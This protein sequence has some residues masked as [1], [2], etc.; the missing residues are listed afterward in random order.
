MR[1]GHVHD[2]LRAGGARPCHERHVLRAWTRA[3]PLD[4]GPRRANDY[5]PSRLRGELP[6]IAAELAGL[7]RFRCGESC[8]LLS[9]RPPQALRARVGGVRCSH[10]P[11]S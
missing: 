8:G 1:L 11:A 5:F 2:R 10:V 6:A 4:G 7:A 9:Q 3:L